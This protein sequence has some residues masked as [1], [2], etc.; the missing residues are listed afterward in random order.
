MRSLEDRLQEER[1]IF[2]SGFQAGVQHVAASLRTAAAEQENAAVASTNVIHSAGA[3]FAA[4]LLNSFANG[5]ELHA[6]LIG[7]RP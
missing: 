7:R 3:A 1:E 2:D 5:A 6:N 4:R